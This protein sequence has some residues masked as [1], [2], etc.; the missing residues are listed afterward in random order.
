METGSSA[1][2]TQYPGQALS[3]SSI[4]IPGR[5]NGPTVRS[6]GRLNGRS[7]YVA[8]ETGT[9][10]FHLADETAGRLLIREP[11][12]C[13]SNVFGADER[14]ESVENHRLKIDFI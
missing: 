10:K 8:R 3:A 14:L 5:I 11:S 2:P 7:I 13:S 4:A 9:V 6:I 12:A 1:P